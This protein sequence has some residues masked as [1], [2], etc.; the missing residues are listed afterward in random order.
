MTLYTRLP[1]RFPTRSVPLS[2][3]RL[4]VEVSALAAQLAGKLSY[5]IWSCKDYCLIYCNF[6]V[7]LW[8]CCSTDRLV[9]RCH[10]LPKREFRPLCSY[11]KTSQFPV[12]FIPVLRRWSPSLIDLLYL[13]RFTFVSQLLTPNHGGQWMILSTGVSLSNGKCICY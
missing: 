9:R 5:L 1:S 11:A 10:R 8:T 2:L 7:T 12:S 6:I 13:C 4:S 3:A